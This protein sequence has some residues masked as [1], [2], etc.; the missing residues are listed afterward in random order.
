MR[1]GDVTFKTAPDFEA[2][3]DAGGNNVYDIIVTASDGMHATDQDVAITVKNQNEA[4][5]VFTSGTSAD[6]SNNGTGTAYTASATDADNLGPLTYTLSGGADVALF[7]INT[8]TGV[9][10]FKAAPDFAAPK[11]AGLDNVYNIVVTASDGTKTTDQN[12][13]ITVQNYAVIEG[14]EAD[15]TII[16]GVGVD[17]I[18]GNA[19]NDELDGGTGNDTLN[20]GAG[21]DN[22]MGGTGNDD[23]IVDDIGD[24]VDE[25]LSDPDD[26]DIVESS[27]SFSLMNS[28][29]VFG[30]IENLTLTGTEN[31]NGTGNTL[32]NTI[33]GNSGANELKSYAGNDRLDGGAGADTMIGGTGNDTYVVDSADDTVDETGASGTETVEASVD[34]SLMTSTK[35]LGT[36]EKLTLTGSGNIKGTGNEL[37]NTIIGNIGANEID[38]GAGADTIDGGAGADNMIGGAGDDI[39]VVDD[40]GDTVNETGA[41]GIETIMAS[42]DFSLMTSTK[43]LGT[44]EKLTLTGLGNIKGTGNELANTI[45]G[46]SGA[47]II[48]GG[49]GADTMSGGAGNDT[50]IVDSASDKIDETGADGIDTV[51]TAFTFSLVNSANLLGNFENLTLTGTGKIN[52]TGNALNNVITGNSRRATNVAEQAV[53]AWIRSTAARASTP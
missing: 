38:G 9:V 5:P 14:S 19:G 36:F 41:D 28:A 12:V 7:D 29:H 49:T 45:I 53:L 1:T 2:P 51:Q 34:F 30:A 48:D 26:V 18:R 42:V 10:T 44:F 17:L 16:G 25:N 6:F 46:N 8:T 11:D 43:V 27:I 39:Y 52:G 3:A 33:I 23:Y 4:S 40:A 37:A 35:V 31:I 50:Y 22:L 21:A 32:N 15:D 47:N 24:I 20:G 13:A